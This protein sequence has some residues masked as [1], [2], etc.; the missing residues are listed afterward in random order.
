MSNQ[1]EK[2]FADGFIFKRRD[3]APDFVIG[4]LSIKIEDAIKFMQAHAK[5]GWCN[6]DVK[7]SGTS[8]K[9]Y[10]ELD[11]FERTKKEGTQET[12]TAPAAEPQK[13]APQVDD[14]MPF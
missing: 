6:L 8:G 2:I 11:T 5:D 4:N 3:N 9:Y 10:M 14:D 1:T 13:P 12:T 7:K